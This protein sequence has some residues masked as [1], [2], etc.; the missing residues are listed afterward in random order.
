MKHLVLALALLTVP[1][2]AFAQCNGV[3]P[4]NT[5]CGN[6]TGSANTPRPTNPSAF[7]GAAGGTNGQIQYNN[8]GALGG[9]TASGDCIINTSTGVVTC[10][11]FTNA[12]KFLRGSMAT[13]SGAL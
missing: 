3:F 5:V 12:E 1:S 10:T 9:F 8:A 13:A 6:I 4:N 7:L 11:G 2:G